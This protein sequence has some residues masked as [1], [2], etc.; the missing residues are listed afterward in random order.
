MIKNTVKDPLQEEML[1]RQFNEECEA[2]GES[3]Y[4]FG[5]AADMMYAVETAE[6]WNALMESV[7][8]AELQ[9]YNKYGAPLVMKEE[10]KGEDDAAADSEDGGEEKKASVKDKAKAMAADAQ[11]AGSAFVARVRKILDGIIQFI[12]KAW[13]SAKQAL[14]EA[15][16]ANKAFAAK[17]GAQLMGS[18]YKNKTVTIKGYEFHITLA[19]DALK[20]FAGCDSKVKEFAAQAVREK[21]FTSD[22][23]KEQLANYIMGVKTVD[24]LK[25]KI[26]V[27]K[28]SISGAPNTAI[29][30]LKS[31]GNAIKIANA[32]FAKASAAIKKF[33]GQVTADAEGKI[34]GEVYIYA[35]NLAKSILTAY[36][37]ALKN[38]AR[39]DRAIC[40]AA[41]KTRSADNKQA[42]EDK[43]AEK[44]AAKAAKKD[45]GEEAAEG[46]TKNESA[47]LQN[48][49]VNDMLEMFSFV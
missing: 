40:V 14:Q 3:E 20:K 38:Q 44:A 19:Q 9:F 42:R 27:S 1:V 33:E 30:G 4:G 16:V 35:S 17:Y 12:Q 32:E 48:M 39:Q 10:T 26:A 21:T 29:N 49:S 45:G 31:T 6:A 24:E 23:A 25:G 34:A 22:H 36:I 47:R 46:E 28:E 15:D 18:E 41:L 11:K 2:V 13:N 7:G 8:I 5:E 37:E 43:K